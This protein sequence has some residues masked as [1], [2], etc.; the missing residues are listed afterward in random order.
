MLQGV[1]I[2]EI[3]KYNASLKQCRDRAASLNAEIEY[4][5]KEIDALCIELSQE[6]GLTVTRENAEQVYNEQ[7]EK[8]N[9]TL[10]SGN[11]VLSKIASEESGAQQAQNGINTEQN[12]QYQQQLQSIA[13][14]Q[15]TPV[16]P[17]M[18]TVAAESQVV[19]PV[20]SQPQVGGQNL[21]NF[22]GA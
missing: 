17:M 12:S 16:P 15:S 4:T 8:I 11:A 10:Q 20:F 6:L 7:L 19:S 22:F 5:N 1:N 21:P 13:S 18:N 2:D 3:K 9:S 14:T